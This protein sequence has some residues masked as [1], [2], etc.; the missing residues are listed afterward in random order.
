MNG[1]SYNHQVNRFVKW[2]LLCGLLS[3]ALARVALATDALWPPPD[4]LDQAFNYTVPGNPPPPIDATAFDI[5]N[6]FTIN[7][8]SSALNPELFEPWNTINYTNNGL[9]VADNAALIDGVILDSD[10][11]C[12]FDFET[13][14]TNVI[15]QQMAGTFY[16]PG[17]IRANSF[18]DEDE[19]FLDEEDVFSVS[20]VGKV[21]ISATNVVNPG[22]IDVGVD[23]LL[24]STG[25]NADFSRSTLT[26]E[27]TGDDVFGLIGAFGTDTNKDWNP[28]FDLRPTSAES[29]LPYVLFLPDSTAYFQTDVQNGGSNVIYRAV[30]IEDT[31]ITNVSYNVY[32]DSADIFGGGNVTIEWIGS[33]VDWATGGQ[34]NN[35]LYLNDDYELGATTNVVIDNNGIPDN[36]T[37]TESTTRLIPGVPAAPG[38]LNVFPDGIITNAYAY[39]DAQLTSTTVST[40]V[41]TSNPSGALTNLPGRIQI[42]ASNELNL[43]YAQ[44]TGPNYMSLQSTNQFD[45]SPGALIQ[46]A[47]S[48]LNLGVTNGFLTVSNLLSPAIPNWSG[49]VQAWSTRW[50]VS[51]TNISITTDTNGVATTNLF[52]ATND[53]RVLIVGSQLTPTT[54]AQVQ[55]LFLHGTNLVLSDTMNII[56]N[57]SV[58]SQ[59][60]TLTTNPIANGAT[61][62]EGELNWQEL[63]TFGTATQFP[64]LLWLTNNGAIM[65]LNSAQFVGNS[66]IVTVIP[67]TPTAAAT[68]TLSEVTGR[69][70]VLVNNKVTIGSVQYAFVSKI[71]NTV[72]NQIK[73]AT[74]F[75]GSMSNLIAAINRAVGAGTNYS[76]NTPANSL[77]SAGLLT[78]H[79]FVVTA[80][81]AGSTGNLIVTTNSTTTTNL[82]WNGLATLAGG[83]NYVA[84]T[85]NVSTTSIPYY[86]FINSGL[87]SDQGSTIS[88]NNFL[89]SGVI[90]N[91]V[92]SFALKSLTTT[93][94]NGSIIAGAN[95]SITADSLLTS[96]VVLSVGKALN[97]AATNLLTDTGV[98][99]G[100][101]WSVGSQALGST[102]GNYLNNGFNLSVKPSVG[103]LLGTTVTNIGPSGKLINN[104]WAGLDLGASPAGYTNNVAIGRLFLDALGSSSLGTQFYFSGTGASNAIY[105]DQ[106]TLLDFASYTNHDANGNIPTLGFNT[107]LVIYYADATASG[108]EV[109]EKLN[110]ANNNHLRWVPSYAGYFSSTNIVYPDGTTN[111]V[112]AAL[113]QSTSIDSDQDGIVNADD[114]TPFFVASEVK[115][116]LTLTNLNATNYAQLSWQSIPSS[117]NSVYYITNLA[118]PNWQ[119][120]TNFVTTGSS[121][122]TTNTIL[123]RLNPVTPRY[124]RVLVSPNNFLYDG[125]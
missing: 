90:S 48:D 63:G 81:A 39:V 105:V 88:A 23:G 67:A 100:N 85:T 87:L 54:L 83:T 34:F 3:L 61:S 1:A 21:I 86:D 124:Y 37:F 12:G 118:T 32:F 59:S 101:N 55:D 18:F 73:I 89:S 115:F 6:S 9:M 22:T 98:T 104:L 38:F 72:P 68:G 62:P 52:V 4:Q 47:Y 43:A 125:F 66:N 120:L 64:N 113:A 121:S 96:N 91:G 42:T 19:L 107:N 36:F 110:G 51:A 41:S 7:F 46:S 80:R 56:R 114:P 45:G 26:V 108:V 15:P 29:S 50:L 74:Q 75:D 76:A 14:T 17:T 94:T 117:T 77:V 71:T 82:T 30:F 123:D 57:L 99:N 5:E 122:P 8:D 35:Y 70:N 40:N 20:S 109:S 27:Q 33:Y 13:Q 25:Q 58:D 111:T 2:P 69:T 10:L 112:N 53:F 95:V 11:G 44:I 49:T 28:G 78:N 16:N 119:V 92:G 79:S 84:G 31:S 65:A 102:R 116:T 106:L 60:L 103:D 93:L 24:Q 97:L